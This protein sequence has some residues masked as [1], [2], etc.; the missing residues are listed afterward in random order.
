MYRP[1]D[2]GPDA[3]KARRTSNASDAKNKAPG[4]K[5]V[6]FPYLESIAR[7]ENAYGSHVAAVTFVESIWTNLDD[8]PRNPDDG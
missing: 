4:I 3:N 8:V 7:I 2:D 5:R 1:N 6:G